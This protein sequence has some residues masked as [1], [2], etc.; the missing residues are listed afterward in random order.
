MSPYPEMT[1]NQILTSWYTPH[2]IIW[3]RGCGCGCF[4]ALLFLQP[5]Q[6]QNQT[7]QQAST[8]TSDCRSLSAVLTK[9]CTFL[10]LLHDSIWTGG[11]SRARGPILSNNQFSYYSKLTK[12]KF[13]QTLTQGLGQTSDPAAVKQQHCTCCTIVLKYLL[14]I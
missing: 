1:T 2:H 3:F 10:N 11:H 6:Q 9:P 12:R 13:A 14:I 8:L 4:M 5:Y 7:I